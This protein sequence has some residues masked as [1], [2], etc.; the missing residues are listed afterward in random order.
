MA[1]LHKADGNFSGLTIVASQNETSSDDSLLPDFFIQVNLSKTLLNLSSSETRNIVF[2]LINAPDLYKGLRDPVNITF[3]VMDNS[4]PQVNRTISET[5]LKILTYISLIGCSVSLFFLL[6]TLLQY[7]THRKTAVDVSLKVHMNLALAL[8]LLNVHF[9]PN[10]KVAELHIPGACKYLAIM[11]HYA[12]LTTFTWMAI[13]GFH[14]YLLLVRV[15]NIYI[16]RYLLKLGLVGWGGPAIVV[17]IIAIINTDFYGRVTIQTSGENN[18]NVTICYVKDSINI[19]NDAFFGLTWV[20][21]L[22]ILGLICKLMV[23]LRTK[24]A[25]VHTPGGRS[26][27]KDVCT[28]LS[29][30][31][32]LGV[33]WGL[34]FFAFGNLPTPALYLFCILNSLQGFFIFLWIYM[35]KR[36]AMAHPSPSQTQSSK[37]DTHNN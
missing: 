4:I 28:V 29:M 20:F 6:V 1:H 30:S 19:V 9:L 12:L 37:S 33:T 3:F 35:S 25:E 16:S 22:A 34:V 13:E 21:N 11:L 32:L 14:L 24:H 18:T 27:W 5:D 15:F 36:Q 7:L 2:C 26:T 8:V 23:S 17:A 31:C 10:P